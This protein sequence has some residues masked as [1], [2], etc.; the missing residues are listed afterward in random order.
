M[1]D[2]LNYLIESITGSKDF[3]I[4][5]TEADGKLEL[6][7]KADPSIVGL[8]IGKQGKTIKNLRKIVAI[9]AALNDKAVNIL[10]SDT[11]S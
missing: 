7:V 6:N 10:V 11:T 9:K 3:E 8:I 2:L 4:S 1:K 5:E